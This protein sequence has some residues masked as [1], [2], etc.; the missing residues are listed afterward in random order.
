M[1]NTIVKEFENNPD[2]VTVVWNAG[3]FNKETLGWMFTFWNNVY[4]RSS[5]MHDSTGDF[6]SDYQQPSTGLP[7]SRSFIIDRDG[8]VFLPYFGH[9]PQFIISKIYE[10]LAGSSVG[11]ENLS[12]GTAVWLRPGE[13]NPFS[14][15]TVFRYRLPVTAKVELTIFDLRG[16]AVRTLAGGRQGA[17]DYR[18][19]WDGLS[20]NGNPVASGVY[21]CRL[22]ITADSGSEH[23]ET[24]KIIVL[25]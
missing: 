21:F 1:Q 20:D 6:T 13:P 5:V 24:R 11:N 9:R 22:N 16:R 19:V 4:L 18:S 17:G 25:K 14:S 15:S 23:S 3:G 2:V 10:A 7:F 8:T 12:G